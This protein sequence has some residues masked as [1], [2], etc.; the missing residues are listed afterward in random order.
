MK[1]EQKNIS[2]TIQLL[3]EK[4]KKKVNVKK[5]VLNILL[6]TISFIALIGVVIAIAFAKGTL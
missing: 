5:L 2:E 4:N 3:N 6:I 1:N